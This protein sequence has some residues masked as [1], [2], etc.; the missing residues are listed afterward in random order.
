MTDELDDDDGGN[1]VL[2]ARPIVIDEPQASPCL[3]VLTGS[4][5]GRV[6]P[7]PIGTAAIGRSPTAQLRFDEAGVSRNHAQIRTDDTGRAWVAD[8]ASSNGTFLNK[9]RITAEHQLRD[10]DTIQIGFTTVLRFLFEVLPETAVDD[11]AYARDHA[12]E[13][14]GTDWL[15]SRLAAEVSLATRRQLSLAVV[16]LEP[17]GLDALVAT[18]GS[19][20]T[21]AA[22]VALA[23]KVNASRRSEAVVARYGDRKL[24]IVLRAC[25]AESAHGFARRIIAAA[26]PLTFTVDGTH[27]ETTVASGVGAL[28][29]NEPGSPDLLAL[30][31]AALADGT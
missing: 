26:T 27:V 30:A 31:D 7:V 6:I 14:Y 22:I 16:V 18:H 1:T 13:L 15:I 25:G 23:D 21:N 20:A 8:L 28:R 10:G 3:F 5:E 12:T 24:A 17:T 19:R 2:G 9:Q 29:D 11:A 4:A